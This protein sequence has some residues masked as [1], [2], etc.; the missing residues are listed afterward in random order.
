MSKKLKNISVIST[1]SWV[2]SN[3]ESNIRKQETYMVQIEKLTLDAS[4]GIHEHEKEKKQ[5]VSISLSIKVKD[6]IGNVE[7]NIANFLSYEDVIKNIKLIIN[8]GHI[9]LVETLAY[10]IMDNI[11]NDYRAL[12]VWLKIEKLEVFE[13][14]QSVG[15]EISK[16]RDS[17]KKKLSKKEFSKLKSK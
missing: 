9:E 4:I 6:N 10:K 16:T 15:I 11:F 7:E 5:K 8:K 14:S 12:S 17:F 2:P 1:G 3:L 13:E